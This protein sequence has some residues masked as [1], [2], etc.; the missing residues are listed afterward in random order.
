MSVMSSFACV[1]TA[2]AMLALG[3]SAVFG[4]AFDSEH[5]FGFT[6]GTDIGEAGDKELEL[7]AGLRA[8]KRNGSYSAFTPGTELKLT[9]ADGL[10]ISPGFG[11]SRHSISGVAGLG[12]HHHWAAEEFS[13]ETK[14]QAFDRARAG[15]GL[16]F[17]AT[18]SV[19]RVDAI[20][21]E[22]VSSYGSHFS[23]LADKELIANRLFGALNLHYDFAAT[24]IRATGAWVHGSGIEASGALAVQV[25][26]GVFLGSEVRYA[27]V[28]GGLGLNDYA[29]D[30]LFVGP[31]FYAKLSNRVWFAAGWNVQ[32]HGRA[33]GDAGR[34]NL[35][36]FERHDAK[37]RLGLSF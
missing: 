2:T 18:P 20:S 11:A 37:V 34:L 19:S 27:R 1:A 36:E 5:L 17:A 23:I 6:E 25:H 3:T 4:E 21:G 31:S 8:G 15:F 14:V 9:I 24:Q 28:Y 26:S 32:V 13:F 35:V 12:D 7:E 16:T 10:R 30:A 33:V 29:G 22:R